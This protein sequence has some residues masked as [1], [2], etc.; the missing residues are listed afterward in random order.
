MSGPPRQQE[1]LNWHCELSI[2]SKQGHHFFHLISGFALWV[3]FMPIIQCSRSSQAWQL[4]LLSHCA[5]P[6]ERLQHG[7]TDVEWFQLDSEEHHEYKSKM[8]E[9]KPTVIKKLRISA[10]QHA[11]S[12]MLVYEYEIN[13]LVNLVIEYTYTLQNFNTL[14]R[15]VQAATITM[16][17]IY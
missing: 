16:Y 7:R 14:C 11:A 10:Q 13:K 8:W 17:A 2:P 12:L 1:Q 15:A 3:H 4:E 5:D 9:S 6:E